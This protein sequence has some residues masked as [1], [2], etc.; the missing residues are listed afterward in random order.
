MPRNATHGRSVRER[1]DFYSPERPGVGCW[2]WKGRRLPGGYGQLSVR[3][4]NVCAHRVSYEIHTGPI[5]DGL[6]VCHRCDNP[7]CVRPD[8][9][10]LGTRSENLQDATRKRRTRTT[11]Q[12][13]WDNKKTKLSEEQVAEIRARYAAG[14]RN[15]SALAR[16]F[17]VHHSRV[18]QLV[19]R[20]DQR[21]EY[22]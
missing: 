3:G 6:D 22:A 1:F 21:S 8:H 11:P 14:E 17:G 13:G 15:Q 10:F 16:E 18:W 7:P 9:L 20:K 12:Y 5:P 4:K 19:N 2:E